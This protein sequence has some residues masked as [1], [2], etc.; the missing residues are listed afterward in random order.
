MTSDPKGSSQPG[1]AGGRRKRPAVTIE[2]TA[3]EVTEPAEPAAKGETSSPTAGPS[4]SADPPPSS[5]A[6]EH[7]ELAATPPLD[8]EAP[9]GAAPPP[10]TS[11]PPPPPPSSE[12]ERPTSVAR[13]WTVLGVVGALVVLLIVAGLWLAGAFE[14]SEDARLEKRLARIESQVL[15]LAQQ[16]AVQPTGAAPAAPPDDAALARAMQRLDAIERRLAKLET[17][18]T[19]AADAALAD[20]LAALEAAVKDLARRTTEPKP[21]ADA[22]TKAV[23]DRLAALEAA[24][25]S[26]TAR[27]A[28]NSGRVDQV[29]AQAQ[30]AGAQA[31][32]ATEQVQNRSVQA[33]RPALLAATLR[34]AVARGDPYAPELAQLKPLVPQAP[35]AP[36]DAF[37]AIG[38]PTAAALARE[39]ADLM[40]SLRARAARAE[41]PPP[42]A[43]VLERLQASAERLVRIRPIDEPRGD[44][45][46]AV[47]ARID[48]S[49]ARADLAVAL[50]DLTKLPPGVRAP[51]EAW[52]KKA[53]A[54]RAALDTAQH[55][56]RDTAAALGKE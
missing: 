17:A 54:R 39:L 36:L 43:G 22:E 32:A 18:P 20:R 16:N 26:L 13:D 48:A 15:Q 53:E 4:Q 9:A 5:A 7:A 30:A 40:P 28:E 11:V 8:R 31:T 6:A 25:K 1:I 34:D 19:P 46:A 56:A 14:R 2:G 41:A 33:V 49:A 38:V 27:I 51:A 37:A 12:A 10:E 35:W 42:N 50:A 3:T 21:G 44:D 55:L 52:I 23:A 45:V 29:A 47:L 24:T